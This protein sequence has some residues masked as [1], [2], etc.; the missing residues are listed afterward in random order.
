MDVLTLRRIN[1]ICFRFALFTIVAGVLICISGVWFPVFGVLPE[2][3]KLLSTDI[4]VF[5]GAVLTNLAIKCYRNPD[6]LPP[7]QPLQR[8]CLK[9]SQKMLF[10][11]SRGRGIGGAFG[12]PGLVGAYDRV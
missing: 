7:N 1:L 8:L 5:F 12:P 3:W 9:S 6:G 4:I 2:F 10:L 11:H